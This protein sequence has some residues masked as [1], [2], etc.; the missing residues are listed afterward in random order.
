M[1]SPLEQ[2]GESRAGLLTFLAG[3]KVAGMANVC[4]LESLILSNWSLFSEKYPRLGID[5]DLI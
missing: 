1:T 5:H 2:S 4:A 3:G